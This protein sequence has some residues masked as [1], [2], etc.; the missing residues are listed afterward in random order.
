[1][2]AKKFLKQQAEQDRQEI[3]SSD[4]GA[5][6]RA[7]EERVEPKTERR[8]RP[9]LKVW[10][11]SAGAAVAAAAIITCVAVY[12][13]FGAP[14]V[15]YLDANV[16]VESSTLEDLNR[17]VKEFELEIDTSAYTYSVNKSSDK[18]SGDTLYYSTT[19]SS[20][21]T[22]VQI[23]IVTVCNP[24]YKYKNFS[25]VGETQTA[26]LPHYSVTYQSFVDYDSQF[27][28]EVLNAKSKTQKRKEFVYV[29]NYTE[30]L[31]SSEGSF[32]EIL[33]SIVK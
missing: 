32:L 4:D 5:F 20:L 26:K 21:D 10:L 9:R 8:S 18:I 11:P 3:L 14:H 6:L 19:L 30:L 16:V 29:T 27:D 24:R 33:Q 15:E 23:K 7:L 28:V 12:A 2:N 31:T 13:P 1:M 25:F 22:L 17:D